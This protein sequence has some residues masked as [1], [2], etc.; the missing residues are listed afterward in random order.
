LELPLAQ[1]FI[2][3]TAAELGNWKPIPHPGDYVIP[4]SPVATGKLNDVIGQMLFI[5]LV[6]WNLA[7]GETMLFQCAAGRAFGH[8]MGLPNMVDASPTA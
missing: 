5:W 3:L 8:A 2:Q 7:L 4:L 6:L 1:L